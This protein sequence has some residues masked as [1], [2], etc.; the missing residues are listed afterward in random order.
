MTTSLRLGLALIVTAPSGAGKSTLIRRLLAEFPDLGFSVSATTR[1]PRPGER[2]GVDYHFVDQET[3]ARLAAENHFAEWAVVHGNSYGTPKQGVLDQLAAGRDLIF[4]ID[5]QGAKA[6]RQNLGLGRTVF[7]LPPSRR[8]LEDRLAG[9]GSDSAETIARRMANA[10]DEISQA[11][12]FDHLVVND[13]LDQ[14]YDELRAVYL[15]E[16]SR[17][18]LHPGLVAAI[19]AD[20]QAGRV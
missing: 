9:R 4:D 12:W 5:V 14:A 15:A 19:L 17:S 8:V 18:V 2:H 11:D 10:R 20:W 16:R 13:V 6:L 7:V 1:A 3:F